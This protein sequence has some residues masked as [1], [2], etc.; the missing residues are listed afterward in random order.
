MQQHYQQLSEED[1]LIW[2]LRDIGHTMRHIS[3]GRGSQKRILIV[4]KETGTITQRALTQRL[5]IRPASASEVIGKLEAAGLIRRTPSQSDRRTADISLTEQGLLQ[6]GQ[7]QQQRRQRHVQMFCCLT[8]EEK[9]TLLALTEKLNASW[10]QLYCQQSDHT[11]APSGNRRCGKT[12][13]E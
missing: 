2:N 5:N 12:H 1:R 9:Q 4:L 10:Q 11:P 3:E 8:Q 13:R 6:A 7:A